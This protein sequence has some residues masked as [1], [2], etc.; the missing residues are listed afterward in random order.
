MDAAKN[1]LRVYC[2]NC[3]SPAGFDIVKQTYRC[4]SC[5]ELTG[6]QEAN[7][8]VVLWRKLNKEQRAAEVSQQRAEE[9]SCP[10]CGALVT[11]AEGE[12]S[13]TCDFCGSRLLR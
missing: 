5:G 10:S 12:A 9:R 11:F 4:P 3:G 1:L 2:K 8:E 6:I 7:E 13:E